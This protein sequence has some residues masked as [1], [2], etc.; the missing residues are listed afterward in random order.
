MQR[1]H[2]AKKHRQSWQ[3]ATDWF[4]QTAELA[5]EVSGCEPRGLSA[6]QPTTLAPDAAGVAQVTSTQVWFGDHWLRI[7]CDNI[8]DK[9]VIYL[10]TKRRGLNKNRRSVNIDA[11]SALNRRRGGGELYITWMLLQTYFILCKTIL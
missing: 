5:E 1:R 3:V 8:G 7:L 4:G 2:Q 6:A 11:T 10:A 9:I